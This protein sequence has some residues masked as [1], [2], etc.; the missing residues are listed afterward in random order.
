MWPIA[1]AKDISED[2]ST[3]STQYNP[4]DTMKAFKT[5]HAIQAKKSS[6]WTNQKNQLTIFTLFQTNLSVHPNL[7]FSEKM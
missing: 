5:K 1:E 4:G 6:G 7:S 3:Q 2:S